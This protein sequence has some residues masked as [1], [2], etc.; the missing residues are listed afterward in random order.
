MV[1]NSI[2][3]S[4]SN[5]AKA[6]AETQT[7]DHPFPTLACSTT[8]MFGW[9][10]RLFSKASRIKELEAE[11]ATLKN[12]QGQLKNG[13]LIIAGDQWLI[14]RCFYCKANYPQLS[15]LSWM[16]CPS[17]LRAELEKAETT[18]NSYRCRNGEC[19]NHHLRAFLPCKVC[20]LKEEA[21]VAYEV[22]KLVDKHA[23]MDALSKPVW[24]ALTNYYIKFNKQPC[25]EV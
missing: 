16:K 2:I 23:H 1:S 7:N 5:R 9:F 17:C 19:E 11:I 3:H 24:K 12:K 8:I 4:G 10:K 21:Q 14:Q 20:L 13:E 18:K 15:Y 25:K 22:I 6:M